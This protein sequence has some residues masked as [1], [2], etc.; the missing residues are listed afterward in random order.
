MSRAGK[1]ALS[2]EDLLQTA[3]DLMERLTTS[4]GSSVD[5]ASFALDASVS[6]DQV[7]EV[8]ELLQGV[9]DER[10][11]SRMAVDYQD[12]AITLTGDAGRLDPVR[13]TPMESMAL[14][15][16]L[17][18]CNI[19]DDVRARVEAALCADSDAGDGAALGKTLGGDRL[20]GG[21]YPVLSEA[22]AIGA[23]LAITYRAGD[24]C[25]PSARLIDPKLIEVSG[26]AAYL[27]AW[28]VEKDAQRSY[29]LD[30]IASAEL[31]EDS[32]ERHAFAP[33]SS[34]DS[35]REHGE[36]AILRFASRGDLAARDWEG[37]RRDTAQEQ[38]DGGVLVHVSYTS[39]PWL[40]SQ[41]ASAAGA[42][43]IED[44]VNLRNDF[45]IWAKSLM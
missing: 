32:V 18:T 11:G 10:S 14:R 2:S 26:D 35:L 23:R 36:D 6:L 41:I 8:V 34:A 29:R 4:P 38:K 13:L 25:S 9:A 5:A 31:T 24:E 3:L 20:L 27:V 16:V 21:F 15:R 19:D 7:D 17:T 28:N 22:I 40:F 42:I 39:A 45:R 33:H 43:T 44:P 12:G 37:I 1:R 30:R